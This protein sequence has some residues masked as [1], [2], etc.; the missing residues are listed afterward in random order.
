MKFIQGFALLICLWAAPVQAEKTGRDN[1]VLC[2]R[3]DRVNERLESMLMNY[4]DHH[5]EVIVL[6]DEADKI[7]KDLLQM[8][9]GNSVDDICS[10]IWIFRHI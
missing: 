3:L 1:S 10:P 7:T 2:W 4:T 6:R 8:N 9:P 5:P